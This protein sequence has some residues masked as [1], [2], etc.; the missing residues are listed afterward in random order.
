M[1]LTADITAF[2]KSRGDTNFSCLARELDM[3][4]DEKRQALAWCLFCRDCF[5]FFDGKWRLK[6]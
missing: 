3:E 4:T 2:L 1:T 5:E 6:P